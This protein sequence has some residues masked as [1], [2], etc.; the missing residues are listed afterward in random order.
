MVARRRSSTMQRQKRQGI[1]RHQSF[2]G[3][4]LTMQVER[5][6]SSVGSSS[7][8]GMIKKP[9][10]HHMLTNLSKVQAEVYINTSPTGDIGSK[11]STPSKEAS[12]LRRSFSLRKPKAN[13]QLRKGGGTLRG[14]PGTRGSC[15]F[16][17]GQATWITDQEATKMY[18]GLS[19]QHLDALGLGSSD[20]PLTPASTVPKRNGMADE[21][22]LTFRAPKATRER[23]MSLLLHRWE[24]RHS[25]KSNRAP[26]RFQVLGSAG[27]P[28]DV[29]GSS[30]DL[31]TSSPSQCSS[32]SSSFAAR[33][34]S[35][36]P[37]DPGPPWSKE[38]MQ[39][40]EGSMMMLEV[41]ERDV[42]GFSTSSSTLSKV[43][44]GSALLSCVLEPYLS[45]SVSGIQSGQTSEGES[46]VV[47]GDAGGG[48]GATEDAGL[49][50]IEE[51]PRQ[52]SLITVGLD[53]L[54]LHSL[55]DA[56]SGQADKV[57]N[58]FPVS[59]WQESPLFTECQCPND[60]HAKSD[61]SQV[62]GLHHTDPPHNLA[63]SGLHH[64][65]P[66]HNLAGSG[67]QT[68]VENWL[69]P[70]ASLSQGVEI[71]TSNSH[72]QPPSETLDLSSH[73]QSIE[74]LD[75][76]SC[77]QPFEML[78]SQHSGTAPIVIQSANTKMFAD[79]Q[80]PISTP[81]DQCQPPI[82][83]PFAH[84][85]PSNSMSHAIQA[86]L[87][88]LNTTIHNSKSATIPQLP[89]L[90]PLN[91]TPGKHS[92][93]S[94]PVEATLLQ[95]SQPDT[96]MD[97]PVIPG[98]DV[99]TVGHQTEPKICPLFVA[100][101]DAKTVE[102]PLVRQNLLEAIRAGIQLRKVTLEERSRSTA[103]TS[104][105]AWDVAAI[106]ERRMALSESDNDSDVTESDW[107]GE[108]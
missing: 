5:F 86:E 43:G 35:N 3:S 34:K 102:T 106:L 58:G 107:E 54:S 96:K 87:T 14:S 90:Q 77:S 42:T 99:Y 101:R 80:T 50:P 47:E 59:V 94:P 81:L 100:A 49:V 84:S 67:K 53:S 16:E 44:V 30:G 68:Q 11:P 76:K 57:P 27:N 19:Q 18:V 79:S 32:L 22:V 91:V 55:D 15:M 61:E 63:G 71:K 108:W 7:K 23:P 93:L 98:A 83:T 66:P 72:H 104:L 17:E 45:G 29:S 38:E 60:A 65:D 13:K 105:L 89:Y 12:N 10:Q 1:G 2:G 73:N 40:K 51:V 46:S 6:R 24:G 8:A 78:H 21:A 33:E 25:P 56:C 103:D 92:V 28:S 52:D 37:A 88:E 36:R 62:I 69:S 70:L 74:I 41:T 9:E 97:F 31:R 20:I 4:E 39:E 82:T 48:G 64:T 85:N 75:Y 95:S 26:K